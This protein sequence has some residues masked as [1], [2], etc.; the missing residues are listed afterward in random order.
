MNSGNMDRMWKRLPSAQWIFPV[1][2]LFLALALR[3]FHLGDKG[4]WGD[5]IAQARW[6]LF[7]LAKMWE[8]FRDPPDFILHFLFG[9]IALQWGTSALWA[10][11]PSFV[12]SVVV[13]PATYAAA[14]RFAPLSIA[15]TAMLLVAVSPFQ[16]WYAQD[17]RMYASLVCFATL[18]LYFFLR[19]LDKP[20]WRAVAGLTIANALAI[21]THLFGVMPLVIEGAALL[22]IALTML[23]RARVRV[24]RQIICVAA[25]FALTALL[26]LPLLPGTL[27]YVAHP[28]LKGVEAAF[29][30]NPFQ[31]SPQFLQ[32]LL[33]DMGLAPDM[34]WRTALSFALALIGFVALART[35]PRAAWILGVWLVLPLAL[36]HVTH[37]GHVVANRY[38][39]FLQPVYLIIIAF[40]IVAFARGVNA[41]L[42]RAAAWRAWKV[43]ARSFVGAGAVVFSILLLSLAPLQALYARAKLNDWQML[44][45][46]L[47]THA[48]PGDVLFSEQDFWGMQK[49]SY[50]MNPNRFSSPP[51]TLEE[52][53]RAYTQDRTMWYVSFGGYLN[54]QQEAWVQAHLTRVEDAAWMRPD[55]VYVPRDEFHFTQSEPLVT[56]YTRAGKI[57]SAIV[58][59]NEL[60]D[61]ARA[62]PYLPLTAGE[63]LEAELALEG[64]GTHIVVVDSEGAQTASFVIQANGETL[65]DER[66]VSTRKQE[67]VFEY[68]LPSNPNTTILVQIQNTGSKPLWVKRIAIVAQE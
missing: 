60:G 36:L 13:V 59:A 61:R 30:E 27:P 56:L 2:I 58:Y 32:L 3:F 39:I 25:S 10:R 5:E 19:V 4:L 54:P 49:L 43:G 29:G 48:T 63:M 47:E 38:L 51:A 33:S 1:L 15:L 11:L 52:L 57:P 9:H 67:N 28:T 68:V 23:P 20:Q 42:L 35:R 41:L 31:L 45:H 53:R 34:G 7:P 65:R 44:A 40:G 55:L 21:Y 14:R 26:T 46:F 37:P 66:V 24:S 8:R 16:I 17:A 18:S 12:T 6:A 64:G 50:Y 62:T 22:G